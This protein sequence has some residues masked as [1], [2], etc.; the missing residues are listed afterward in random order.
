MI[1]T[2]KLRLLDSKAIREIE[3]GKFPSSDEVICY[4]GNT[5]QGIVEISVIVKRPRPL[6]YVS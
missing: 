3:D 1:K 5:S 6:S 2:W 4:Y